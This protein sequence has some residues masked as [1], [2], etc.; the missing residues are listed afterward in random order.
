M[1][2]SAFKTQLLSINDPWNP[3]ILENPFWSLP[4]CVEQKGRWWIFLQIKK[5]WDPAKY[6]TISVS[7]NQSCNKFKKKCILFIYKKKKKKKKDYPLDDQGLYYTMKLMID[8]ISPF[9]MFHSI[10]IYK[11]I[12]HYQ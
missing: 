4:N 7:C 5:N 8:F 12:Y 3:Y 2:T 6:Y 11:M 1:L 10:I 9:L